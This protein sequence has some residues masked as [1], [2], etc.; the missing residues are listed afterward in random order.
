[1]KLTATQVSKAKPQ[2]KPYKLS[3]GHGLYLL[4]QPGG[5]KLWRV[6]YR[7]SGRRKTLALGSFPAISLADARE[8]TLSTKRLL[9]NGQDPG[10]AKKEDKRKCRQ[11]GEAD[12]FA[13]MANALHKVKSPTWTPGHAKQWIENME[14]WAFPTIGGRAVTDIEPTDILKVMRVLEKQGKYETRDR[15]LQ[16]ISSTFK[17]AIA[18]GAAKYN[19]SDIRMALATRPK[20]ENFP[21]I[22]PA[23]LPGFLQAVHEYKDRG[24]TSVIAMTAMKL[25][26]LTAVRTSEVRFA[27]W[28]D[29]DLPTAIW[30]IPAEQV[31]RKGKHGHRREHIVPLSRQAVELLTNLIPVTGRMTH[32][33]PNRNDP[34]R[35]ITENTILKIIE[36]IGYKGRMTGHGFRSLARTIL[37]ERGHRWEVLEAMLSHA[38]ENQTAAA[39]VRTSYLEE[40]R[41]IMQQWA[42]YLET[43]TPNQKTCIVTDE[44]G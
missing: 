7:F 17:Y 2:E 8:K 34:N 33:F 9:S 20:V 3:D 42:D 19:P 30:T 5:G 43:L 4:V 26:M 14:K 27:K 16:T 37:A 11:A 29:F 39:Y 36:N 21:C 25:L 23:E 1:M 40:R 6:D 13:V 18:V 12:T 35:V 44:Q 15:L 24:K 31:G 32:V 41:V 28:A 22:S 10:E 38:V